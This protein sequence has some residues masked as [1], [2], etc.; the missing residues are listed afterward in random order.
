MKQMVLIILT[1][2]VLV[3][4]P[5]QSGKIAALRNERQVIV[6][7]IAYHQNQVKINQALMLK[8]IDNHD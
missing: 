5:S 1:I 6:D 8:Q 7:S 3:T 2:L 4:K